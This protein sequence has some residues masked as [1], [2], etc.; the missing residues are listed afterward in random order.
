VSNMFQI[1]C[2]SLAKEIGKDEIL[3]RGLLRVI[4]TNNVRH[5]QQIADPVKAITDTASYASRMSY[6]E[7][8]TIL[9]SRGFSQT[10]SSVGIKDASAVTARLMQTLVEQQSLFTMGAR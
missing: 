7:W 5:L 1:L 6:Q 3:C 10:L 4:I 2:V 9:E 8:K